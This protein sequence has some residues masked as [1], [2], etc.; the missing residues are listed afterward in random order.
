SLHIVQARSESGLLYFRGGSLM[1]P[2]KV[3]LIIVTGLI[4]VLLAVAV[5]KTED[6]P[7]APTS[8]EKAKQ[9]PAERPLARTVKP[10][11]QFTYDDIVTGRSRTLVKPKAERSD[12]EAS[13]SSTEYV[14]KKNDTLEKIA[15]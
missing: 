7:V 3:A 4:A 8:P 15:R 11:D 1:S 6:A 14:V 2:E 12:K 9:L 5:L 13:P 10:L